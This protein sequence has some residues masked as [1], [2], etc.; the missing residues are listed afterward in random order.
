[1]AKEL[2]VQRQGSSGFGCFAFL[3]VFPIVAGFAIGIPG[4][5]L[6]S[7]A[8]VAYLLVENPG[9]VAAYPSWWIGVALAPVVA[10]LLV[11]HAGRGKEPRPQKLHLVRAGTVA[12]LCAVAALTAMIADRH[13]LGGAATETGGRLRET[14]FALPMVAP[15]IAVVTA[16]VCYAVIR[17]LDRKLPNRIVR[18]PSTAGSYT[19]PDPQ[20][21]EIWWGEVE[22]RE[23]D[24]AKDR[25]FVILRA[26]P[27]HLEILQITSQ[28]KSHRD[29]HMRFWTDSDDPYAVTGG[30]LELRVRQLHRYDLRRQDS[31]VCPDAIWN[32][33]HSLQAAQPRRRRAA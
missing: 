13:Y 25:P 21:G 26:L 15:L 23:G 33:V 29:D 17:F 3:F 12:A 18:R 22:F 14:A 1:M 32:R 8:I 24:G 5:I 27:E 30:Y 10:Y 4:F 2:M 9:Q 11:R 19:P 16:L 7:P 28:D 20:P 6:A 31:A